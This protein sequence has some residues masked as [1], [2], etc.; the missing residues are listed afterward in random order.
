MQRSKEYAAVHG[1][2]ASENCPADVDR[3]LELAQT[4]VEA[5]DRDAAE[6]LAR[7]DVENPWVRFSAPD[8]NGVFGGKVP[9]D[10]PQ[11][12][13]QALDEL[14]AHQQWGKVVLGIRP[15]DLDTP[16]QIKSFR[17]D[18]HPESAHPHIGPQAELKDLTELLDYLRLRISEAESSR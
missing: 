5:F 2:H 14:W 11:A 7:H 9:A 10:N 16:E 18:S 4:I 17:K 12:L 15:E 1:G 6:V 13:T 3:N 8:H